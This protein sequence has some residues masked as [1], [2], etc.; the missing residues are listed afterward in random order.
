MFFS[1]P[2]HLN[3]VT[4]IVLFFFLNRMPNRFLIIAVYIATAFSSKVCLGSDA[5][6]SLFSLL[7]F[8]LFLDMKADVHVD[9]CS[10]IYELR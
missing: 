6:P 9:L 4:K 7:P 2:S 3:F 5:F 1:S 10:Q 8:F